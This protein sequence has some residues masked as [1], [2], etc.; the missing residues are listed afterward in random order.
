MTPANQ[1]LGSLAVLRRQWRQRVLFESIVWIA[2]ATLVAVMVGEAA[3]AL[4]GAS[5]GTV[6]AMRLLGYTLITAAIVR[7]LVGP[8]FRRASNQRFALYVEERAP[9]L[10]QALLS[11]IHELEVPEGE[12]ASSS[13]AARLVNHTLTMVRPLQRDA[14]IE[15]PRILR[16][17]RALGVIALAVI[18][19]FA[20]GPNAL[21]RAARVMF[22]PWSDAE[23]AA[24]ALAIRVKP[25]NISIPRGAALDVEASLFGFGAEGAETRRVTRFA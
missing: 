5:P 20:A 1:L 6:L 8:M 7:F 4:L 15:R 17:A 11:A 2:A 21:R 14:A 10:R 23:A 16:A 25:G 19:L 13:L 9:Q 18:L 12:G 22:V 24:P 3:I